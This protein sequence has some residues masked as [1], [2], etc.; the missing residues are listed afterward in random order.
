MFNPSADWKQV[1]ADLDHQYA[2]HERK[3]VQCRKDM[4]E[5]ERKIS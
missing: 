2:E 1:D 4:A 3:M 5:Y